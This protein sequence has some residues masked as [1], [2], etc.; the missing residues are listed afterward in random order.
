MIHALW[1]GALAGAPRT[2]SG[3]ALVG[4]SSAPSPPGVR[5]ISAVTVDPQTG[6]PTKLA[7]LN[8]SLGYFSDDSAAADDKHGLYY[9]A[10]AVSLTQS[11]V[12][13]IELAT[14]DVLESQSFDLAFGL[15][16]F[17]STASQLYAVAAG[18][19]SSGDCVYKID[20]NL[21]AEKFACLPDPWLSMADGLAVDERA[22]VVY[23]LAANMVN[24]TVDYSTTFGI[25]A[26]SGKLVS[27]ARHKYGTAVSEIVFSLFWDGQRQQVVGLCSGVKYTTGKPWRGYYLCNQTLTGDTVV[28]APIGDARIFG[29]GFP[30]GYTDAYPTVNGFGWSSRAYYCGFFLTPLPPPT[31]PPSP[32]WVPA[33]DCSPPCDKACSACC[34]DPPSG[35][36]TGLCL[37]YPARPITNCSQVPH[38]AAGRR[39]AAPTAPPAA[40]L[41]TID[42]D[43]GDVRSTGKAFPEDLVDLA[44]VSDARGD[45]PEQRAGKKV[46][47]TAVE[48][49]HAAGPAARRPRMR[50]G[51]A[52]PSIFDPRTR[53]LGH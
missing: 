46:E 43:S 40:W 42:T 13:K 22:A 48:A 29:D 44:Y 33:D 37:G 24:F 1:L 7:R 9:V 50:L 25:A 31:P 23:V 20:A 39:S 21:H 6:E 32:P 41:L 30:P 17:D 5:A 34:K 36:D 51:N 47:T 53:W 38:G 19:T 8:A 28:A 2:S 49:P 12:S 26:G 15:L 45:R 52:R 16:T 27:Q 18:D 3:G 14:G 35:Q 10:L 4:I 11:V